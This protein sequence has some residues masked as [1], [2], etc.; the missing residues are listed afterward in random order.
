MGERLF[1][2]YEAGQGETYQDYL[3]AWEA[4]LNDTDPEML[5]EKERNQWEYRKLNYQRSLR[6]Q[7]TYRMPEALQEA[8]A[9]IEQP[10]IWMVITEDWCGDSAQTLPVIEAIAS[11]NDQVELRI[12]SRDDHPAVMEQ[13]LTAGKRAIPVLVAFDETGRELFRWGPRPAAAAQLFREALAQG[14]SKTEIYPKLHLWYGRDRGKTVS[15]EFL[16]L[17][18]QL[19]PL[20]AARPA[21]YEIML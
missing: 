2:A 19:A 9:A 10:Q 8:V 4:E 16:E 11:R 6:V 3:A 20:R 14:L 15:G 21:A 17:L 18:Q 1:A 7:K 5:P 12:L 13:Y